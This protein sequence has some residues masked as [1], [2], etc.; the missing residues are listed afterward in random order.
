MVCFC[1]AHVICRCRSVTEVYRNRTAPSGCS[2]FPLA[3][4]LLLTLVSTRRRWKIL[5]KSYPFLSDTDVFTCNSCI[6]L[7]EAQYLYCTEIQSWYSRSKKWF[8]FILFKG[9]PLC[10]SAVSG[11]SRKTWLSS[12]KQVLSTQHAKE[13]ML[14]TW[15]N[16][17]GDLW[18]MI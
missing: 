10:S 6:V 11:S 17:N 2:Q 9:F 14:V 13:L 18:S 3:L 12:W 7:S 8:V 16:Q 15:W 1:S 4:N 5:D